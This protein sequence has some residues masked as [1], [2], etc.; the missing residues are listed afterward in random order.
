MDSISAKKRLDAKRVP[1]KVPVSR[2]LPGETSKQLQV[3]HL[4]GGNLLGLSSHVLE[5]P[6]QSGRISQGL[7]EATGQVALPNWSWEVL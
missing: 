6:S 7:L 5:G 3:L 1:K 2:W 4:R